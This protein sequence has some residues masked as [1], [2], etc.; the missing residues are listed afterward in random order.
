M[1]AAT[2]VPMAKRAML[3]MVVA[4]VAAGCA[5]GAYCDEHMITRCPQDEGDLIAVCTRNGEPPVWNGDRPFDDPE[6]AILNTEWPG[7]PWPGCDASGNVVCT[8]RDGAML[9]I[10]VPA[11]GQAPVCACLPGSSRGV[12]AD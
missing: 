8:T 1:L 4:V 9:G 3:V 10:L 5:S 7:W 2:G 11:P 12:C 6:H